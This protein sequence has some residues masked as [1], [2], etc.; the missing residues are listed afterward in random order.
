MMEEGKKRRG[1]KSTRTGR[2]DD[3]TVV[4]STSSVAFLFE[5]KGV[6]FFLSFF[7]FAYFL[8]SLS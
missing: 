2:E 3:A 7:S 6:C 5:E 4:V 8:V 1:G